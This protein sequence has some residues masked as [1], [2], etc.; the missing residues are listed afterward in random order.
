MTGTQHRG[1]LLPQIRGNLDAIGTECRRL[2]TLATFFDTVGEDLRRTEA[3]HWQSQAGRDFEEL[4]FTLAKHCRRTADAHF[5]A[6]GAL[7]RYR[8]TLEDLQRLRDSVAEDVRRSPDPVT[9]EAARASVAR[10]QAQLHSAGEV[11]S[12]EVAKAAAELE[13][14]N[15]LLP[16]PVPAMAAPVAVPEP[17]PGRHAATRPPPTPYDAWR[18]PESYRQ[19]V[20]E[21]N[22]ALLDA[23]SRN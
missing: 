10:W 20:R 18:N 14:V 17:P 9:I 22:D 1:D 6:A 8:A 5:T 2:D 15:R 7:D 19:R 11:A 23:V 13:S 21:I 12:R 16:E 4:G 3:T